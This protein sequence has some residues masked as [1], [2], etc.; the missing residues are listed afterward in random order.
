M[1]KIFVLLLISLILPIC[2]FSETISQDT[3]L[4]AQDLKKLDLIL[5]QHN[6]WESEVPL[7]YD[8]IANYKKLCKS[9]EVTDSL[10]RV[11][12]ELYKQEITIRDNSIKKLQKSN[13]RYKRLS[14]GTTIIMLVCLAFAI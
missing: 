3:L 12:K 10:N 8:Q 4:T 11:S 2:S 1:R 7:L 6:K 14:V 5:V 9:Y 13:R